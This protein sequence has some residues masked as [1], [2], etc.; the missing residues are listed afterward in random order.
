MGN[1]DAAI[2]QFITIRDTGATNMLNRTAVQH[3]AAEYG[4]DELV[5]Y[6]DDAT[7]YMEIINSF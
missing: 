7:S 1:L 5:V 3:L 2:E 4:F 6:A